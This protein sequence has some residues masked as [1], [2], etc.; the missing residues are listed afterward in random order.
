MFVPITIKD[1][2]V[3]KFS[4]PPEMDGLQ[5]GADA[6]YCRYVLISSVF[7]NPV[8]VPDLRIAPSHAFSFGNDSLHIE[9]GDFLGL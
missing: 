5:L 6:V 4:V 7:G 3:V 2:S 1:N 8:N 9:Q